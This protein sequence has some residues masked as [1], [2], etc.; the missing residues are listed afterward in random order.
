MIDTGSKAQARVVAK[1]V[2]EGPRQAIGANGKAARTFSVVMAAVP[3][4]VG[5]VAAATD[6]A[7]KPAIPKAGD[8]HP[9]DASLK[10][11]PPV[12]YSVGLRIRNGP[13]IASRTRF[14]NV[15]VEYA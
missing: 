11:A 6:P 7:G 9:D 3:H 10:A 13:L 1:R 15:R 8:P 2:T 12:I 4:D 14:F 5:D